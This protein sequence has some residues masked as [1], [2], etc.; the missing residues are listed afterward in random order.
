MVRV[1]D[2]QT[3]DVVNV[4]DGKNLGQI[5]DLELDLRNGRIEAIVVLGPNKF[6]G[7]FGGGND[8]VIPWRNIVKIGLDVVLVKL[9]EQRLRLP[10]ETTTIQEVFRP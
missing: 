8:I 7:M 5:G 2:F 4:F 9:D 3:K 10:E 6:F 1:S